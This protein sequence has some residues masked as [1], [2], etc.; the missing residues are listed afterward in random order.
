MR[1]P[2]AQRLERAEAIVGQEELN[3]TRVGACHQT[4]ALHFCLTSIA[5]LSATAINATPPQSWANNSPWRVW[6][7]KSRLLLLEQF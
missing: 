1:R 6:K 7:E 2:S 5:N 3:G 4:A